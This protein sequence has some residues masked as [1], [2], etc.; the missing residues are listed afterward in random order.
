MKKHLSIIA[1]LLVFM[2]AFTACS[3]PAPAEPPADNPATTDSAVAVPAEKT[4]VGYI[5]I[6]PKGDAGWT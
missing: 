1:L 4:K 5:Y 2:M 3:S 6:G